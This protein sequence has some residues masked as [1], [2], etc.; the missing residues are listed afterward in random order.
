MD[1]RNP[2]LALHLAWAYQ[3]QGRLDEARRAFQQARDLGWQPARSD[4]LER[5]F[6]DQLDRTLGPGAAAMK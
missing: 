3:A 1:P 4:P 2:S 6:L 5:S